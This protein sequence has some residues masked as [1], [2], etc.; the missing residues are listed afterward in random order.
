MPYYDD[1]GGKNGSYD[2]G[3]CV[4]PINYIFGKSG[5]V[6]HAYVS[7]LCT[8]KFVA[9]NCYF[10]KRHIYSSCA[11]ISHRCEHFNVQGENISQ[12]HSLKRKRDCILL[13]QILYLAP[14]VERFTSV[15]SYVSLE[16]E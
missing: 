9:L 12:S 2:N 14:H 7:V 6:M 11:Y 15:N 16:D 10:N 1:D 3:I 8:N 13:K 5:S 4:H